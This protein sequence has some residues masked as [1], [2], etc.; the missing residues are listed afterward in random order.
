MKY[1][2][3]FKF[4]ILFLVVAYTAIGFLFLPWFLVNK[5]PQ[6]LQKKIGINLKISKADF[7]PYTFEL[8]LHHVVLADLNRSLFFR[9]KNSISTTPCLGSLI[10]PCFL[11]K[12]SLTPLNCMLNFKK[13]A[14]SI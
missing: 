8:T 6:I 3:S 11:K 7:N 9:S 1:L 5:T 10:K 2:K 4:W 13:M 14:F 12:L